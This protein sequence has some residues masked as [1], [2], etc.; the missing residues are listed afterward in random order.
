MPATPPPDARNDTERDNEQ[1]RVRI[2]S[3]AAA[4]GDGDSPVDVNGVAVWSR[5]VEGLDPGGLR[6]LADSMKAK[7]GSGVIVLGARRA[8]KAQIIVGVT[9]DLAPKLSA[10]EIVGALAPIVGGGGGG[11]AE[12]A[13]AGGPA[14]EGLTEA[15]QK[16]PQIVGQMLG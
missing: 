10:K 6:S 4:G 11:S 12:M 8:G 15:L 3:E 13:Q 1:L 7:L 2:A 5:E 16:V 9:A 14:P